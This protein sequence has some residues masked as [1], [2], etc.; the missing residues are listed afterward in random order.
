M[1]TTLIL[2]IIIMFV[3]ALFFWLPEITALPTIVGYDIDTALVNGVG[4]LNVWLNA[5]WPLK[6]MI[7]GFLAL[8]FYYGIK[9]VLIFLL[10]HR[11]PH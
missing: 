7:G 3:G 8:M 6:Y 1:I 4:N 9:M 2:N 11:A 5:F 10:G